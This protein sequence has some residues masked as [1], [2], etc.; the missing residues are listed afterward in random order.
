MALTAAEKQKAY[1]D[2]QRLKLGNV[3]CDI[4]LGNVTADIGLMLMTANEQQL[5]YI[6]V[7]LTIDDV[8]RIGGFHKL[9]KRNITYIDFLEMESDLEKSHQSFKKLS[10]E[11]AKLKR[12]NIRLKQRLG[13]DY[14]V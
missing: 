14:D 3:T 6:K 10:D 7:L 1:R 13:E 8:S 5:H 4:K 9:S 2:R 12:E 11:Y